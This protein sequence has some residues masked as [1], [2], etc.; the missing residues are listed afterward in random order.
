MESDM[1]RELTVELSIDRPE[2]RR[3]L[4]LLLSVV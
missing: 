1:T 3:L 4:V 2:D